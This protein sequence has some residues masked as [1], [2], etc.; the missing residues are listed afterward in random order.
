MTIK[1]VHNSNYINKK[2]NPANFKKPE[3][4]RIKFYAQN[5]YAQNQYEIGALP[6]KISSASLSSI[7]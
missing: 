4:R 1:E 2:R 5:K 6:L 3:I 7:E